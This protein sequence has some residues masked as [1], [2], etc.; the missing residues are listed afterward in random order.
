MKTKHL[1]ISF[2]LNQWI[3]YL[4]YLIWLDLSLKGNPKTPSQPFVPLLSP[5]H[6]LSILFISMATKSKIIFT[7]KKNTH[8]WTPPNKSS[9]LSPLSCAFLLFL[10]KLALIETKHKLDFKI[11]INF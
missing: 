8:K 7:R 10:L 4:I 1:T 3:H 6:S 5:Y 9:Q 2:H 11:I